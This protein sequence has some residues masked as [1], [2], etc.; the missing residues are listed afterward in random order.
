MAYADVTEY[1]SR[2]NPDERDVTQDEREYIAVLLDDASAKL[3]GLLASAGVEVDESD[4]TQTANIKRVVCSMVRDYLD[5]EKRDGVISMSQG[6]GN[7][8]ASVQW[9][10]GGREFTLTESDKIALGIK[11]RG[12]GRTLLYDLSTSAFE[13]VGDV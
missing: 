6:V 8:N 11:R 9:G 7:T 3:A 5:Y 2:L 1:L 4:E 12:K 10:S 13:V